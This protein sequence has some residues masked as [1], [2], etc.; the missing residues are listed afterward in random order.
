MPDPTPPA[1]SP[2]PAPAPRRAASPG[3]PAAP[4][5]PPYASAGGK[6]GLALIAVT[7]ASVA[8]FGWVAW[9]K[10]GDAFRRVFQTNVASAYGSRAEFF[11]S[12]FREVEKAGPERR[13][14]F[15]SPSLGPFVLRVYREGE[16]LVL[17]ASDVKDVPAARAAAEEL[18]LFQAPG[19]DLDTLRL[20]FLPPRDPQRLAEAAGALFVNVLDGA[21]EAIPE[22]GEIRFDD[23]PD[24][25]KAR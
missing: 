20:R 14:G 5:R 12:R 24:S 2:A 19:A 25:A 8:Y 1:S 18:P 17:D 11:V 10:Y 23:L 22:L 13:F 9:G 4:K 15:F 21:P 16:A 7:A 3:S 6:L